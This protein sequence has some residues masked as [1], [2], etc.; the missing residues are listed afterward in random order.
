MK[1]ET[2][3]PRP[4][5]A[6]AGRHP[7]IRFRR[8]RLDECVREGLAEYKPFQEEKHIAVTARFEPAEVDSDR[9]IVSFMLAQLLSNAVKYADAKEGNVEVST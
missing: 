9:R 7:D 1:R 5:T 3:R 2:T 8:F 6:S 4:S